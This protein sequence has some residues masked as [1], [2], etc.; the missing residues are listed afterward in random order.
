[1]LTYSDAKA[2]YV[3]GTLALTKAASMMGRC[4]ASLRRQFVAEGVEIRSSHRA[5][6]LKM[7]HVAALL[8]AGE[9]STAQI[10]RRAGVSADCVRRVRREIREAAK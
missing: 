6:R 9:L 10:R 4:P 8:E 5:A 3:A 7:D 2:Q 1:M